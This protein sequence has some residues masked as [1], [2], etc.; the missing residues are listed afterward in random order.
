MMSVDLTGRVAVITGASRGIGAAVAR[1]FAAAGAHVVL[2][3]RTTGALEALDDEIRNAGGRATLVPL[4][5]LDF[6]KVDTLG[7]ALA[8]RFGRCD[9]LVAN[10]GMLG[11]LGPLPH[12]DAKEWDRVIGLN[13][14]ANFRLV[15]T[16]DPLLR[17]SDAGRAI[18]VTSGA[19]E[20]PRAY[21]G[22]YAVSKAGLEA[23]A[24]SYAAENEKTNLRVNIIDPGRVRTKMRA[25]A[26][27]GEDPQSV[28]P[29]EDVADAFL[30]LADPAITTHG[31][32]VKAA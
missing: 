9:I 26:Y 25:A 22:A 7:P 13:L 27:P 18:F 4:N 28:I 24:R 16:L 10:A 3:A 17:A 8:E 20:G 12:G 14:T 29:P 11:T 5:L 21:W 2:V 6:D 1:R 30:A 23:M 32:R 15:R 31:Q 19:A